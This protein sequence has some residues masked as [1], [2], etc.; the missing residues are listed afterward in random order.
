LIFDPVRRNTS[1]DP[2]GDSQE[3]VMPGSL[4]AIA[5]GPDGNLWFTDQTNNIVGRI[6]PQGMQREFPHVAGRPSSPR[7]IVAGPDGNLWFTD[8]DRIGQIT[9][10]G[11]LVEFSVATPVPYATSG[12][13]SGRRCP[14]PS[15]SPRPIPARRSCASTRRDR[16]MSCGLTS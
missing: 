6:T 10:T 12:P 4:A 14:T 8:F 3:F 7:G 13:S 11:S 15:R 16:S 1:H 2:T 5:S 9:T